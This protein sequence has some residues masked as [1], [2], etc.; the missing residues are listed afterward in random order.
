VL[1]AF[2]LVL[3]SQEV[4]GSTAYLGSHGSSS[5]WIA[6]HC[7]RSSTECPSTLWRWRVSSRDS[8]FW[9]RSDGLWRWIARAEG[10][11]SA[12]EVVGFWFAEAVAHDVGGLMIYV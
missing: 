11:A 7:R 3:P 1:V 10:L 9:R 2:A 5:T 4:E 12:G 8:G 6:I